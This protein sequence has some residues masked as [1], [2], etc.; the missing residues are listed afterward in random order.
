MDKLIFGVNCRLFPAK[1]KQSEGI[2]TKGMVQGDPVPDSV[3][4]TRQELEERDRR[5]AG[6]AFEAGE[7]Y[8]VS[9]KGNDPDEPNK[10][11]YLSSL[12]SLK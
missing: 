3:I 7:R 8:A 1:T 4:L 2:Y 10:E 12:Q 11:Q 5:I 6:D 9:D